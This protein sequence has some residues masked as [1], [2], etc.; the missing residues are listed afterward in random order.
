MVARS[1]VLRNECGISVAE[2]LHGKVGERVYLHR[3]GKRGHY[4]SA[5]AVYKPLHHKYAEIHYG[6]LKAGEGGQTEYIF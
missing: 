6:L 4:R 3:G 1:M 5:E 2:I